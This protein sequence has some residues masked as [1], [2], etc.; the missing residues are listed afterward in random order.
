[1]R[2]AGFIKKHFWIF[3]LA[4]IVIGLWKPV[5]SGIPPYLPELLLGMMLFIVFLKI[6][7]LEV[8]EKIKDFRL[9]IFIASVYMII[10][11]VIFYFLIRIF[12]SHLAIGI[13]E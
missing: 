5:R 7:A 2:I 9:M 11:P 6:D 13:Y 10:V 8:L 3:L 12:D 4:G 1:M